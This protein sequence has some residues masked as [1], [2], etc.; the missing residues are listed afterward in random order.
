MLSVPVKNEPA[1]LARRAVSLRPMED[2]HHGRAW[3]VGRFLGIVTDKRAPKVG[4]RTWWLDLLFFM[5]F[6][7][8]SFWMFDAV[9]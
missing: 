1:L 7:G 5:A 8:V 6:F 3:R 2:K 9:R 4:S